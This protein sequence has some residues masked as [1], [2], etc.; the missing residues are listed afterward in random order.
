[1]SNRFTAPTIP[2]ALDFA[3]IGA[4]YIP[5]VVSEDECVALRAFADAMLK[6]GP[7]ARFSATAG[8]A[9]LL[10]PSGPMGRMAAGYLKGEPRPVR[11]V[12]LNKSETANWTVPWHQDR[13][14]AVR[15]PKPVDG[16]GP[17]TM[18]SG[19][20][21]VEPP[22]GILAGMVTIR[23][24]LDDCGPDN[25][26]LLIAPGSHRLGRLPA[27]EAAEVAERIGPAM[28]L[29]RAGDAWLY[30]TP[31]LH[32]SQPAHRPSQRRVLQVDYADCALPGGL[33]WL[34]ISEL[35]TD[36]DR[37]ALRPPFG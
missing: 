32:A 5:Q 7:G 2:P 19:L 13:T 34:G 33:E 17:W 24:H 31:I 25:A 4:T 10:G 26:P 22:F 12:L 6:R 16:F 37:P 11:A 29:A 3:A 9:S 1:M 35:E 27:T 14:I 18:K 23:L 21:H 15:S 30:A 36:D 20:H 28:C 8:L